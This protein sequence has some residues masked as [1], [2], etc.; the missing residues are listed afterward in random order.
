MAHNEWCD[1]ADM[2]RD[3][4]KNLPLVPCLEDEVNQV[5]LNLIVNAAHAIVDRRAKD[6]SSKGIIT[7]TSRRA[8]HFAEIS[9]GDTGIGIPENVKSRIFEPFFSTKPMGK[10]TGQGLTLAHTVVVEKHQGQIWFETKPGE[11]TTFFVRLPL[12]CATAK[13]MKADASG[14]TQVRGQDY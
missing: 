11:G 12:Q 8:G 13:S 10:G 3:L 14:E 9:V 4:D 1:V 2:I 5:V 7:I 6:A